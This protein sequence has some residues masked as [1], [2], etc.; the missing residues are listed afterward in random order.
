M[1]ENFYRI[2]EVARRTGL[3]KRAIRYYEDMEL[4]Q[5][6]RTESQYRLY[7]EEDIDKITRI[8]SYK[9]SLGF[10]LNEIKDAFQLEFV[11]RSISAGEKTDLDAIQNSIQAIENQ[12]QLIEKKEI[13]MQRV[14]KRYHEILLELKNKCEEL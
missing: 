11:I 12:I 4:I 6:Q 10:S 13:T 8:R 2:E 3:T 14:K 7:S 9:D 1:E 5:P